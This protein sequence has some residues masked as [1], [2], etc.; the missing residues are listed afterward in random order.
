MSLTVELT[1]SPW[2][3]RRRHRGQPGEYRADQAIILHGRHVV[4]DLIGGNL[5]LF[6]E[7]ICTSENAAAD[8]VDHCISSARIHCTRTGL[9]SAC[10]R[11]LLRPLRLRCL[12]STVRNGR[13]RD[14]RARSHDR[15]YPQHHRDFAAQLLWILVMR[16][17]VNRA[18]GFDVGHRHRR[19]DRSVFHVGHL[20]GC[21]ILLV[22]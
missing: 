22:R 8:C 17:D 9:P 12:R 3:S 6:V 11:S 21:G 1:K 14:T 2:T 10:E 16:V 13:V 5:S 19:A 4:V 18:I 7:A 15:G 20:V